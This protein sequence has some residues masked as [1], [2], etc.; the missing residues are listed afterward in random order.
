MYL[1]AITKTFLRQRAGRHSTPTRR[2]LT[3]RWFIAP[4]GGK[5]PKKF[6][7]DFDKMI[8]ETAG[9]CVIVTRP[10][11]FHHEIIAGSTPAA[12]CSPKSH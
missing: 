5:P 3:P 10:D 6:L 1:T 8:K 2:P 12:T 9:F 11:G 7:A 4:N